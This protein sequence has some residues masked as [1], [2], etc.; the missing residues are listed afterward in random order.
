MGSATFKKTLK[1]KEFII[2]KLQT[3]KSNLDSTYSNL[4]NSKESLDSVIVSLNEEAK[5]FE[6]DISNQEDN[7]KKLNE[8]Y[9]ILKNKDDKKLAQKADLEKKESSRQEE[10]VKLAKEF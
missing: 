4:I 6:D 1:E 8:M 10:R 9:L 3:E 7:Y 2:S 5:R